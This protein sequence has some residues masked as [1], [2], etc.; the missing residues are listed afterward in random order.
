MSRE[1]IMA[2]VRSPECKLHKAMAIISNCH[3]K[4]DNDGMNR[5]P[6]GPVA[7]RGWQ[8]EAAKEILALY[9]VEG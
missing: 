2:I 9:G 1:E 4:I 5:R 6:E 3:G 7:W 8:I